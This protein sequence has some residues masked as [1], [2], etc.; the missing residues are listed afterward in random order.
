[1]RG[2]IFILCFLAAYSF[3]QEKVQKSLLQIPDNTT[4]KLSENNSSLPIWITASDTTANS[5][6]IEIVNIVSS[7][8]EIKKINYIV[9]PD[10]A[11]I[12][13]S[14]TGR[15][16]IVR[17]DSSEIAKLDSGKYSLISIISGINTEPLKEIIQFEI[18]PYKNIFTWL[19]EGVNW[20][21]EHFFT[22]LWNVIQAILLIFVFSF[23]IKLIY[24]I[25]KINKKNSL[26][27]LAIINETGKEDE[28]KGAAEGIDDVLIFNLQEISKLS[29]KAVSD[30]QGKSKTG[31]ANIEKQNIQKINIDRSE[32]ATD[33]QKSQVQTLN[34]VGGEFSMDLQKIGDISIGP[35][36]IPLGSLSGILIK[37]FGGNFVTGALQRYGRHNRLYIKLERKS[38]V[39]AFRKKKANLSPTQYF[40]AK[41]TSNTNDI[42]NMTEGIPE[43]VNELAFKLIL[44]LLPDVETKNWIAYKYFIDGYKLYSDYEKNKTRIDLLRDA[45]SLWRESVKLDPD[46]ATVFY[47]LGVAHEKD[48]NF[49]DAKFH[50]QKAISLNP[51]LVLAEAHFNL[52]R[53]FWEKYKDE[54]RTLEELDL[55]EKLDSEIPEIYNLRGLV[56]ATKP[57]HFSKEAELYQKAINLSE[58]DP[59]P[60]Y[61]HNLCAAKYYLNL[62]DEA[63]SAGEKAYDL[64]KVK[65]LPSGL[66]QILGSI[67]YKKGIDAEK[68]NM[69]KI[70]KEEFEKSVSYYEEG[71]FLAPNDRYIMKGYRD[72]LFKLNRHNEG[73]E[74]LK[75]LIRAYPEVPFSYMDIAE[76]LKTSNIPD[77]E[78][79]IYKIVSDKIQIE[80]DPVKLYELLKKEENSLLQIKIF[81]GIAGSIFHILYDPQRNPDYLAKSSEIFN[82]IFQTQFDNIKSLIDGELFHH[83]GMVLYKSGKY[84]NSIEYFNKAID[85]YNNEGR[86]FDL[87]QTYNDLAK[88][89]KYLVNI[90]YYDYLKVASKESEL[91]DRVE[92]DPS[93]QLRE[94]LKETTDRAEKIYHLLSQ[95]ILN[96]DKAFQDASSKYQSTNFKS[97]AVSAHLDNADFLITDEVYFV[98]KDKVYELAEYE[99]NKAIQID[100]NS[101][102]AYH[103][104]GNAYYYLRQYERAIAEYEKSILFNFNLS[105]SHYG[106]GICYFLM[107]EYEKA[108]VAF[109]TAIKLNPEYISPNDMIKPDAYQRLAFCLEKLGEIKEAEKILIA[110][111]NIPPSE[112]KNI[113]P[114]RAKYHLLLGQLLKKKKDL[115]GAVEELGFALRDQNK[116]MKLLALIELADIYADTGSDIK[117]AIKYIDEAKRIMLQNEMH[118]GE[119]EKVKLRNT[120]GWIL[121]KLGKFESA[122]SLLEETL[123]SF[124][125]DAK[126][127]SRLAIA[128]QK[129]AVSL[130]D[131]NLKNEYKD[132]SITQ[133]KLI[134]NLN[135]DDFY[136]KEADEQILKLAND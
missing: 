91:K 35:V 55:A 68:S 38:S 69:A 122:V 9:E 126:Y 34:V 47:N 24:S 103:I 135:G 86:M 52:A 40:E 96:T 110:A 133:W 28:F 114:E 59:D 124:L 11:D 116:G 39:L 131:V 37:L 79:E 23:I 93:D 61:F 27:V 36:K 75:R 65:T 21:L 127:H 85:I 82:E 130:T 71:I 33:L 15:L 125:G 80:Q 51:K 48:G 29:S 121:C 49:E 132:K 31:Q 16:F 62:L 8:G 102:D 66:L 10:T 1:M 134:A 94:E 87:A 53:L 26:N 41:W 109:K 56:F 120:E 117:T 44:E 43:A 129:Y 136:K 84:E 119:E 77:D 108:S 4:Y 115:A 104:K 101:Y 95:S 100:D 111:K 113:P 92:I 83:Y 123:A 97:L 22:F 128:Y 25:L 81:R 30:R 5:V 88:A 45:I 14:K 105:G 18:V 50:Y 70:K 90:V 3:P 74:I 13:T 58:E 112:A 2:I 99:C 12:T 118:I 63:Q 98:Y 32:S 57:N 64:Y 54:N 17:F 72:T 7:D 107:G 106:I 73:L 6:H 76:Y 19:E 20:V 78:I 42:K 89:H 46:F 67:H 60:V